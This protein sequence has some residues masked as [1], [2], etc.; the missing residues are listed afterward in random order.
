VVHDCTTILE[1]R[2]DGEER[3]LRQ[4]R[5]F[6]GVLVTV[7]TYGWT[8]AAAVR[9]PID[10]PLQEYF[11]K[12]QVQLWE[13]GLVDEEVVEAGVFKL[14]DRAP[15]FGADNVLRFPASIDDMPT[16]NVHQRPLDIGLVDGDVI[17][18]Y[19]S[20]ERVE[21]KVTLPDG[22]KLVTFKLRRHSL[23]SR[24]FE[25]YY[26][27]VL[28]NETTGAGD[29]IY[30]PRNHDFRFDDGRFAMEW[31]TP[32]TLGLVSGETVLRAYVDPTASCFGRPG[33]S[34]L[35]AGYMWEGNLLRGP[36]SVGRQVRTARAWRNFAA[37]ARGSILSHR[38][39]EPEDVVR[40]RAQVIDARVG[41]G[42]RIVQVWVWVYECG[43]K[44]R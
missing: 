16:L 8:R 44:L 3:A 19:M 5:V 31:E 20:R 23:L 7:R 4:S 29:P 17:Y 38:F 12:Y 2:R 41:V 30:G 39:R 11:V 40:Q 18:F 35:S 26:E 10:R 33:S 9:L 25:K 37:C 42:A 28:V 34:A 21:I 36:L 27:H 1:R 15:K 24:M 43:V 13:E 22:S 14:Y 6:G 32:A